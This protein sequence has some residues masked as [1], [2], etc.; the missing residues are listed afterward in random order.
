MIGNS[1]NHTDC[2]ADSGCGDTLA[3]P[4]QPSS[5][6]LPLSEQRINGLRLGIPAGYNPLI[7]ADEILITA[8]SSETLGG[9]AFSLRVVA[10]EE[11]LAALLARFDDPNLGAGNPIQTE[12]LRGYWLPIVGYGAIA[13]LENGET[14]LFVEALAHDQYWAAFQAT[15]L[16]MLNSL[17]LD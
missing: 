3:L 1:E 5:D 9:Y 11:A 17:E 15:F 14:T 2:S 7:L 12:S 6:P 10:D 13:V 16:A 8:L 4:A